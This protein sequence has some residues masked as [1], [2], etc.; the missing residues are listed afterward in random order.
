MNAIFEMPDRD[1]TARAAVG[2]MIL[3]AR[4]LALPQTLVDSLRDRMAE[5][6]DTYSEERAELECRL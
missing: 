3:A 6:M 2:Y 5:T 1:C 4:E